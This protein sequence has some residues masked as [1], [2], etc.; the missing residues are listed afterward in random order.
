VP[1]E[2]AGHGDGSDVG[3]DSYVISREKAW[4][5]LVKRANVAVIRMKVPGGIGLMV[6]LLK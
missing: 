4:V 2:F 1:A 5:N 6:E 3:W